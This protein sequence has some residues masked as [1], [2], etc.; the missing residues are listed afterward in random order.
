MDAEKKNE[1]SEIE[2]L[3]IT[4]HIARRLGW[5]PVRLLAVVTGFVLIRGLL[6]LVFRYL[7]MLRRKAVATVDG[8]A[9]VLEVEWSI[10]GK[11][12]RKTTTTSPVSSI[13]AAVF[14]NRKRYVQLI[15]GF[16]FLAVGTWVGVQFL[17]D[18]LRAGYPVWALVG[19]G[20]VVGG[21]LI[22]LALYLFIPEGDGT[23]RVVLAMGPWRVRI[24]G[25]V[26][27]DGEKFV[28]SVRK[29]WRD[30]PSKG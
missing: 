6:S 17:V 29:A 18:G 10:V 1:K 5:A 7:L 9:L 12:F 15:V 21:I 20:S 23:N 14:E 3:Q 22:D 8:R 4:G 19:A 26:R 24:A 2:G 13:E 25:V 27:E 28:E 16:G 30:S 11:V